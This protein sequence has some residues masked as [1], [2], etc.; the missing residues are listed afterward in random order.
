MRRF[1]EQIECFFELSTR[2][3]TLRS[4]CGGGQL[5]CFCVCFLLWS[6]V[7]RD[8]HKMDPPS[9]PSQAKS[10]SLRDQFCYA[11][12]KMENV[13]TWTLFSACDKVLE[14]SLCCTSCPRIAVTLQLGRGWT[15]VVDTQVREVGVHHICMCILLNLYACDC[16]LVEGKHT[17][18]SNF[19]H[20]LVF[21]F[22]LNVA[23]RNIT[24]LS[25]TWS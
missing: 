6:T 5:A 14:H 13:S 23:T 24:H 9:S 11:F 4:K 10:N 17:I 15:V 22:R 3:E 2:G 1:L 7:H 21:L 8:D 18:C 16:H 25:E 19:L 12:V 20:P